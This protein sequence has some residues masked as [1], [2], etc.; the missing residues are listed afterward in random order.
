MSGYLGEGLSAVM[1]AC[2]AEKYLNQVLTALGAV[3]DEMVMVDTGSSDATIGI[4]RQAGCR[5]FSFTWVDDFSLARNFALSKAR[6]RWI[7]SV[8]TDEVLQT[9]GA[10]EVLKAAM[11]DTAAPAYL[12]YQDNLYS[13]G[14]V[15]PNPVLRLFRNDPRIRFTNPVHECVSGTLFT[16]W[17]RLRLS[18]LDFH[19]LHFGYLDENLGGKAVRNLAILERWLALEPEHIFANFKLGSQL[20]DLGRPGEALVYLDYVFLR[21]RDRRYRRAYPFLPVF[22]VI[23]HRAL[24]A[25]GKSAQ[26]D[27][28]EQE[29]TDWLAA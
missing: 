17:P 8:D 4:A 2:N 1:I 3:A 27:A 19:L 24:Q 20:L 11:D 21:F 14:E 5:I 18:T 22:V 29:A 26:A 25:A 28:F 23:Y 10:L 16:A 6:F 9:D 12:I 15:K 7:L 13:G